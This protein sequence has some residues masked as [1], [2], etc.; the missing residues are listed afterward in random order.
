MRKDINRIETRIA[1]GILD[2]INENEEIRVDVVIDYVLNA[3]GIKEEAD[4]KAIKTFEKDE[5]EN[6]EMTIP[7]AVMQAK[8]LLNNLEN[9]QVTEIDVND[10][11]A[12]RALMKENESKEG[13]RACF[14]PRDYYGELTLKRAENKLKQLIQKVKEHEVVHITSGDIEAMHKLMDAKVL[15]EPI[16]LKVKNGIM[17]KS[18]LE[19]LEE[20][21]I[22]EK[23]DY[24]NLDITIG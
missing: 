8:D 17:L 23:G 19:K 9:E 18:E 16:K 5:I 1:L 2:K 20:C 13:P 6:I 14:V 12:L 24:T 10:I 7:E 21:R 11:R 22:I 3:L 15:H 4:K